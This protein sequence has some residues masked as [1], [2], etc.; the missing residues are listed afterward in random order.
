MINRI[1]QYIEVAFMDVPPT[2][3]SLELK[4]ELTSNMIEKYNDYLLKGDNE[5]TAFSN[6]VEHVGDLSEL[7]A[8]LKD[9]NQVEILSKKQSATLKAVAVGLYIISPVA[10]ILMSELFTGP[11]GL[12]SMFT[13]IALATAL[14][15]YNSSITKSYTR[16]DET[17]TEQF[18]EWQDKTSK[19][20][21]SFALFKSAFWFIIIALYL[22]ISFTTFRW[23]ITWIIFLI[24]T[25]II[26]IVEGI[27]VLRKNDEK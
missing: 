26:K 14:L 13:F 10:L 25:A 8:P 3:A 27:L 20:S 21:E 15:I 9:T 17:M 5:E 22:Y 4:E 11:I 16:Q 24:A 12:T 2:K 1:K 7:T 6:V 18:K 19:T 23:H